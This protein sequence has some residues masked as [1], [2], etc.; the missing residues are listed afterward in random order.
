MHLA[1]PRYG[2]DRNRATRVAERLADYALQKWHDKFGGN[3]TAD[4]VSVVLAIFEDPPPASMQLERA[5]SAPAAG[6]A[7]GEVR[8]PVVFAES[9]PADL[10]PPSRAA[11]APLARAYSMAPQTSPTSL[12]RANKGGAESSDE[13]PRKRSKQPLPSLAE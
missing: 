11:T 6:G 10:V 1:R 2:C 4:N 5:A 3:A 9:A 8:A 13:S 7:R 12:K